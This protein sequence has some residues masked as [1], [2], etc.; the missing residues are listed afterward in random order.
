[1]LGEEVMKKT[2]EALL[3]HLEILSMD[4]SMPQERQ[5]ACD[6]VAVL[7]KLIREVGGSNENEPEEGKASKCIT[8]DMKVDTTE[9]DLAIVKANQ[10]LSLVEEAKKSIDS[11]VQDDS[12]KEISFDL[13]RQLRRH[14]TSQ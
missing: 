9:L 12:G 13:Q 8:V 5:D 10:L 3:K 14:D 4:K 1:M 2:E 7:A 6:A 11:L